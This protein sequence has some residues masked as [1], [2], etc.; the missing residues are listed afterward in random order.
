MRGSV[1][2]WFG[3]VVAA[4]L[5]AA[6][7]CSP[8]YTNQPIGVSVPDLKGEAALD[9]LWTDDERYY[10]VRTEDADRGLLRVTRIDDKAEV[11]FR[12]WVKQAYERWFVSE[13]DSARAGLYA[14]VMGARNGRDRVIFWFSDGQSDRYAKLVGEKKL[15]GRVLQDEQKGRI[16]WAEAQDTKV[17]VI[18]ENLTTDDIG[19][20]IK[21]A[22]TLFAW[23]HPWVLRRV[24]SPLGR[25]PFKQ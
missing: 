5:M 9:G 1:K 7:G 14:W 25:A 3:I 2:I 4:V 18:L 23:E 20:I 15:P 22:E 21:H 19:V 8:V 24:W 6:A 12:I 16:E 13:E 11:T 17:R 10:L